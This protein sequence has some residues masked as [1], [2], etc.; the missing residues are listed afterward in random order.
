MFDP[1]FRDQPITIDLRK[2]EAGRGAELAVASATRNFWQVDRAARRIIDRSRHAGQAARVRRRDRPHVL[3][4]QRRSQGD[5][6]HPPHRRRR[7]AHCADD[8][9]QRHHD[10]GHARADRRRRHASS[11][12][13]TR[14]GRRWSSTSSCSRSIARGCKEY[15]L[16]IASPGSPPPASTARSTST[17]RASRCATLRNLTQADVFLTN[18]PGA[19][20][21]PA[22]DRQRDARAGQSAAAH[23][24]RHRGA[25]A[26][27]RAR[28]GAGHDLRADRRRRRA[29]RSRSR[30]STT[31]TSASTSTSRRARITTTRCRWR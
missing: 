31:R 7:A 9:D 6:R 14:R 20:L 21:P 18:L 8:G 30:R 28:A 26:L 23:V 27:R 5:D 1:T 3:P 11:A 22:E 16:Q 17:G 10:Q 24:G 4:E 19:L 12:R 25:G 2:A 15:G 13:S 29:D